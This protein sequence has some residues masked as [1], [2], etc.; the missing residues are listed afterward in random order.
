M[1][2]RRRPHKTRF[3]TRTRPLVDSGAG[4]RPRCCGERG[5]RG[6]AA[7]AP[8]PRPHR[9]AWGRGRATG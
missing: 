2:T 9:M 1:I 5:I 6:G 7:P 3:A 4:T 8:R